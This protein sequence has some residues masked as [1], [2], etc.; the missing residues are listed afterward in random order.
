MLFLFFLSKVYQ[1]KNTH[2]PYPQLAPK[3]TKLVHLFCVLHVQVCGTEIFVCAAIIWDITHYN[4]RQSPDLAWIVTSVTMDFTWLSSCT[5]LDSQDKK[6]PAEVSL[7]NILWEVWSITYLLDNQGFIGNFCSIY[8]IT[9]K[10]SEF[11]KISKQIILIV[12]TYTK[13]WFWK[14]TWF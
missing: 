1:I 3:W 2:S 4:F 14:C 5:F 6:Q 13:Y 12:T 11:N 9:Y 10:R 8:N 7:Y